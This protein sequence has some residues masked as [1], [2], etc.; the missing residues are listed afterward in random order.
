[1]LEPVIHERL[2]H[3]RDGRTF[4]AIMRITPEAAGAPVA[5]PVVRNPRSAEVTGPSINNEKLA[6]R[7][8]IDCHFDEAEDFKLHTGLAYQV[9]GGPMKAI[10]TQGILKEVHFYA[11]PS[12]LRKRFGQC[13]RHLPLSEKEVLEGDGPLRG[14]DCLE[15]SRK[16]LIAI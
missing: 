13:I 9:H 1:R 11:G 5:L 2:L 14:T 4:Q 7:A 8:E 10:A 3:L 12:A 16:N 6:M 15:Q